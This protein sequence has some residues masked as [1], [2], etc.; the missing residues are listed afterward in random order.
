M[1]AVR[2]GGCSCGAVHGEPVKV[3]LCHCTDCRK[4]TGSLYLAYADWHAEAFS[5]TG[6]YST[7]EGRSFCPICG[8]RLFHLGADHAEICIGSLD[9]APAGLQP[10]REGWIKRRE[11]WLHAVNGASQWREDPE[12]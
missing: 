12:S 5:V 3:G 2:K 7:Y 9:D 4:E 8:T 6:R 1:P 10:T 11:P